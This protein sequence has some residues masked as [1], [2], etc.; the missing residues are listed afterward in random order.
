[1]FSDHDETSLLI[2][3]VK[4]WTVLAVRCLQ[5]FRCSRVFSSTKTTTSLQTPAGHY[6]TCLTDLTTRSR[7]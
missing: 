7:R 5:R 1:M 3:A 6:H 2:A 4:Y